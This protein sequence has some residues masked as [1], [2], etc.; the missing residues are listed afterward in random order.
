[1]QVRKGAGPGR[2]PKRVV[3]P[4]LGVGGQQGA[5]MSREPNELDRRERWEVGSVKMLGDRSEPQQTQPPAPYPQETTIP[6]G[7]RRKLNDFTNELSDY[8]N[9]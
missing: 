1:M 5:I 4:Q 8:T 2:D 6:A 7:E 9:K 3:R